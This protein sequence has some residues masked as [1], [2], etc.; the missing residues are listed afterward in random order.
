V[1]SIGFPGE[2]NLFDGPTRIFYHPSNAELGGS[3]IISAIIEDEG[4]LGI[5]ETELANPQRLNNPSAGRR[6]SSIFRP[7]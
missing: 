1:A 2:W 7:N 6:F 3:T 4:W 5:W